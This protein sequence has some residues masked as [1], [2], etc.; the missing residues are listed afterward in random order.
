MH[1]GQ[2][3][4]G[5]AHLQIDLNESHLMYDVVGSLSDVSC[6]QRFAID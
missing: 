2:V 6:I 5:H 3:L 1:P 4:L